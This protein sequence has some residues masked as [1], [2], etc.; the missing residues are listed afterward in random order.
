MNKKWNFTL[1]TCGERVDLN[2]FRIVY[3]HCIDDELIIRL[4]FE[5]SVL[6][7]FLD[8]KLHPKPVSD[9]FGNMEQIPKKAII[10]PNGTYATRSDNR[11][12]GQRPFCGC[13][14]S[15]DVGEYNTCAHLCEYCYANSSK[16][17]ALSNW[18][19]HKGKPF[20]ESIK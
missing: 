1:A 17:T 4:A 20:G 8:V 11:D 18:M 13:M 12:K 19:L 7:K 3:N 15:K 10:L 16:E 9:L 2:Q 6:M 14:R 5:D